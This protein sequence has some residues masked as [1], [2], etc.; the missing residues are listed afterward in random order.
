MAR[1]LA[2]NLSNCFGIEPMKVVKTMDE[3]SNS[4]MKQ[5]DTIRDEVRKAIAKGHSSIH[6]YFYD[7]P[8]RVEV[9]TLLHNMGVFMIVGYDHTK[10]G[11][12]T[13]FLTW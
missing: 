7:T 11:G 13:L 4:T 9:L 1:N 3:I 2:E 10:N 8:V 5:L 6:I 12:Y